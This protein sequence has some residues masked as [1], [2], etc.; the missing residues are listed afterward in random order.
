MRRAVLLAL[1]AAFA[2]CAADVRLPRELYAFDNGTGRDQKLPLAQQAAI[3]KRAGYAGMGLY[4]GTARVPE[5]LAELDARGLKLLGIYV[6]SFVDE[7]AP[8]IDPGLGGA[9]RRLAGRDTMIVLTLRGQGPKAEQNAV[10]NVREVARMAAGAGL[11]VCLYPHVGF[12]VETAADALRIV[13]KAGAA[14][15]G[16][17]LNFHHAALFHWN[18]C[19]GGDLDF[20]PLIRRVLPKLFM[21]S[22]NGIFREG[23]QARVERLDRGNL[24]LRPFL[25]ALSAEGYS[26][27]V[28]LQS[29]QVAGDIETNLRVSLETW[30][31]LVAGTL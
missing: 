21:V 10:A 9:I 6:H 7:R 15:V 19:G 24:P 2:A 17:A 18:R 3:L 12:Y 26:G 11:R 31:K 20:H 28:C 29:Y 5:L 27:P 1:A 22:V 14:N 13:E 16:L 25:A 23:A 30:R 8:R 4:T